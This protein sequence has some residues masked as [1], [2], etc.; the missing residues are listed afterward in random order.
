MKQGQVKD[1]LSYLPNT[2]SKV[3]SINHCFIAFLMDVLKWA[4]TSIKNGCE[5]EVS[6]KPL[7]L[8]KI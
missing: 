2:K 8:P 4:A 5:Q 6:P 7:L 3:N 1:S